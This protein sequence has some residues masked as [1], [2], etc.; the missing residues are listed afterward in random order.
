MNELPISQTTTDEIVPKDKMIDKVDFLN[1]SKE[2]QYT[3]FLQG[4]RYYMR[5]QREGYIMGIPKNGETV[6]LETF[7]SPTERLKLDL[8]PWGFDI[9]KTVSFR[10]DHVIV[11][12]RDLAEGIASFDL[13]KMYSG[14]LLYVGES[15]FRIQVKVKNFQINL[16]T[17]GYENSSSF[18]CVL[19][20]ISGKLLKDQK[21]EDISTEFQLPATFCSIYEVSDEDSPS[22]KFAG[23]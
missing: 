10:V 22:Y 20:D 4:Y 23:N 21:G 15:K 19:T 18:T 7:F 14:D 9:K 5:T 17:L 8:N 16:K 12:N 2:E 3:K 13:K 1:L 11:K 6:Y